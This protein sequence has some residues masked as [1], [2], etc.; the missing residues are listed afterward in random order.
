[1]KVDWYCP[2][3]DVRLGIIV[4]PGGEEAQLFRCQL[5]GYFVQRNSK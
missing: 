3:C 1:M 2:E 5:E 4:Y